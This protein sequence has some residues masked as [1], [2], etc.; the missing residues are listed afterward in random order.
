MP[1][2]RRLADDFDSPAFR[3]ELFAFEEETRMPYLSSIERNALE[4]GI[5]QGL[6]QGIQQGL[7]EG[8][9]LGI[10][11]ALQAKYGRQG[12]KLMAQVRALND[13]PRLRRFARF[14]KTAKTLAEVREFLG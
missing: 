13:L 7:Q 4:K 8:L 11:I 10:E 2:R 3:A 1:R 6:E 12:E 14:L 5:E 9:L